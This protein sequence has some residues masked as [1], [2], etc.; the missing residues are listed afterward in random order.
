[1]PGEV[2]RSMAVTRLQVL[3]AKLTEQGAAADGAGQDDLD[4][5][6]AEQLIDLI[7]A[8]FGGLG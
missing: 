5:A 4:S 1:M 8:E 6:T 7:D 3:L 2:V